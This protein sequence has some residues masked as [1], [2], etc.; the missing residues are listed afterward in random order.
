VN[1]SKS[2]S[3]CVSD[4]W[5]SPAAAT[6]IGVSIVLVFHA[7]ACPQTIDGADAGVADAP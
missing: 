5:M 1:D 2:W 7:G 3:R 6:L 4:A